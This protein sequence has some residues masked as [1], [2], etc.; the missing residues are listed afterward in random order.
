MEVPHR[1]RIIVQ[2]AIRLPAYSRVGVSGISQVPRQSVL[3]LCPG[4][5]PRPN[6]RCLA[7]DGLVDAAPAAAT[8]K[9]S[10][11]LFA[12]PFGFRRELSKDSFSCM[13]DEPLICR[14]NSRIVVPTA[15]AARVA[16]AKSSALTTSGPDRCEFWTLLSMRAT[17]AG[18]SHR[19]PA[20][21]AQCGWLTMRLREYRYRHEIDR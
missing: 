2:P 8:T 16:E 21:P 18:P 13:R 9:A 20:T 6:R 11:C 15:A 7:T 19:S 5:R 10:A 3:C 1:A 14:A 12:L 4:P 17:P